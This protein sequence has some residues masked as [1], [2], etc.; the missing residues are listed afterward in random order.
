MSLSMAFCF[1]TFYG[2]PQCCIDAFL[3]RD[4]ATNHVERPEELPFHGS[5]FIP[6]KTCFTTKS[7]EQLEREIAERRQ[8]STPFPDD[9]GA[10]AKRLEVMRSLQRDPGADDY[11]EY[12][13]NFELA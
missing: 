7:P 12:S 5:G 10:D 1:G 6:C 8:C 9:S 4:C 3:T 11:R 2:Y 13:N